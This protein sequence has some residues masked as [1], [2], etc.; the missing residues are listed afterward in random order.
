MQDDCGMLIK[1]IDSLLAKRANAALQAHGV[2]FSQI[3]TL[4]VIAESPGQEAPF[5]HIERTLKVSQPTTAGLIARLRDKGLVETFD[6]PDTPNAK[7][8]RLTPAGREVCELARTDMETEDARMFDGFTDEE[9]ATF[10]ALLRRV[11][12]NVGG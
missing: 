9:R 5:K 3:T 10:A 1:Q 2:T 12:A 8:A 6:A 4:R 11:V 7:I